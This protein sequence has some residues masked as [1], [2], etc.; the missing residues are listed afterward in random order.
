MPE[1]NKMILGKIE[2]LQGKNVVAAI[3]CNIPITK[4][5][6]YNGDFCV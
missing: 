4:M 5:I 2:L 1:K 6:K 3:N